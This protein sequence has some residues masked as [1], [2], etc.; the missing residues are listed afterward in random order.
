MTED[1]WIGNIIFFFKQPMYVIACI[2]KSQDKQI[3]VLICVL[4]NQRS[5]WEDIGI[6]EQT[7][8]FHILPGQNRQLCYPLHLTPET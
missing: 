4:L 2:S 8:K 3:S 6:K 5:L 7:G 1:K